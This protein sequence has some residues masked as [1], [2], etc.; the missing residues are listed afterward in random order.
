MAHCL[1]KTI[2]ASRDLTSLSQDLK[3]APIIS[4]N[5]TNTHGRQMSLLHQSRGADSIRRLYKV[6]KATISTAHNWS[7]Y[8]ISTVV[9]EDS[10]LF[11]DI[12]KKRGTVTLLEALKALPTIA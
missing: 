5:L 1:D 4:S 11:R 10:N 3:T 8:G 6:A 9:N 7:E 2:P 12:T